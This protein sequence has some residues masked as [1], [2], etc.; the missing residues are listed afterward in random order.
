VT[1]SPNSSSYAETWRGKGI[2]LNQLAP[3]VERA[4]MAGAPR[5]ARL[6]L[7]NA[8]ADIMSGLPL[9]GTRAYIT[10]P[11]QAPDEPPKDEPGPDPEPEEATA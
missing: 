5:N 9:G 7:E 3:F 2:P 10:W 1:L 8:P 4:I 6:H 11:Y